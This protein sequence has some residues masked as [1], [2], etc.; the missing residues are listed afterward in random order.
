M[1]LRYS[2]VVVLIIPF[3]A[4]GC[5]RPDL[6]VPMSWPSIGAEASPCQNGNRIDV[7]VDVTL[8]NQ[9]NATASLPPGKRW[10]GV[11][12]AYGG[13]PAGYS[14]DQPAQLEAGKSVHLNVAVPIRVERVGSEEIFSWWVYADPDKAIAEANELNNISKGPEF[15]NPGPTYICP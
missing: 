15:R 4:S 3:V 10:V 1:A 7:T 13:T 12:S 5:A 6:V 8:L 2:L 9:G 14:T 11:Y